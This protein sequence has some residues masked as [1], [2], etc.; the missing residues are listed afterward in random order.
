MT[1]RH[2]FTRG[3]MTGTV[4][5][6]VEMSPTLSYMVYFSNHTGNMCLDVYGAYKEEYQSDIT[7]Q[8]TAEEFFKTIPNSICFGDERINSIVNSLIGKYGMVIKTRI[9]YDVRTENG[10]TFH[11][12]KK[13]DAEGFILSQSI[14][15]PILTISEKLGLD[16]RDVFKAIM[17]LKR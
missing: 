16:E 9:V 7:E 4:Y 14:A 5:V 8:A 12:D 15:G 6:Q 1:N 11:F 17:E 3:K 10:A 13:E 2:H